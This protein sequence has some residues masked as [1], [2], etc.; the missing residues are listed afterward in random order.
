MVGASI[1]KSTTYANIVRYVVYKVPEVGITC[2]YLQTKK[3]NDYASNKCV[4]FTK[5][6]FSLIIKV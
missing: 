3:S 1:F 6:R 5:L 2:T 4:I